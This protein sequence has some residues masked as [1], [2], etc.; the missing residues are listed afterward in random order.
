LKQGLALAGRRASS[1]RAGLR[2]VEGAAHPQLFIAGRSDERCP[3]LRSQHELLVARQLGQVRRQRLRELTTECIH[4]GTPADPQHALFEI[5]PGPLQLGQVQRVARMG[6]LR[7]GDLL[8]ERFVLG[9][10]AI[11]ARGLQR[12]ERHAPQQG[13]NGKDET[14]IKRAWMHGRKIVER[15]APCQPR[16]WLPGRA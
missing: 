3:S 16:R 1:R 9:G 4:A 12:R 7:F 10:R 6:G 11:G 5:V 2:P 8:C 14:A 15:C 13:H